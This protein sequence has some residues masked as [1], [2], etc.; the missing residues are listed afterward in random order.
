[1][2]GGPDEQ[3]RFLMENP[4]RPDFFIGMVTIVCMYVV[5]SSCVLESKTKTPAEKAEATRRLSGCR[6]EKSCT[7]INSGASSD[8]Y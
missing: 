6:K 2:K 3:S 5:V 8:S 4:T 1:M 7:E